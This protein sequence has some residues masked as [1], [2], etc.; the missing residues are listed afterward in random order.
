[1]VE[2]S[3]Y[4]KPSLL[5]KIIKRKGKLHLNSVS[6]YLRVLIEDDLEK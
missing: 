2:V 4:V 6:A 1:M 5:K 3:A